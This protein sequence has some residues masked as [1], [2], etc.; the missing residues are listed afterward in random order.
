[1]FI[2]GLEKIYVSCLSMAMFRLIRLCSKKNVDWDYVQ[3]KCEYV[4]MPILQT[5]WELLI[6]L[7]NIPPINF[8]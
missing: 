4:T 6:Y 5:D 2:D 8:A 3:I 1:M 7:L